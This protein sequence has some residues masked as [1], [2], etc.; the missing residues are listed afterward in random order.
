MVTGSGEVRANTINIE[1]LANAVCLISR[2]RKV[3]HT[4]TTKGIPFDPFRLLLR[5]KGSAVCL[6]LPRLSARED[7]RKRKFAFIGSVPRVQIRSL[8]PF[9]CHLHAR[10][11]F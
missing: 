10:G 6:T 2:L 7:S 3:P 4:D 11:E 8:A 1:G 5:F 9:C